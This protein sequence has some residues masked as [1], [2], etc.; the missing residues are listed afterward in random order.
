VLARGL[1]DPRARGLISVTRVQLTRDLRQATVFVTIMPA[2][3]ETLTLHALRHAASHVRAQI[4]RQVELRQ[5]PRLDFR[6]DESAKKEAEVLTELS[7]LRAPE[8]AIPPAAGADDA[9]AR[10]EEEV[11]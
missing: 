9:P 4:G 1:N 10:S 11:P 7:R 3:H 5:V 2:E 6:V 8:D